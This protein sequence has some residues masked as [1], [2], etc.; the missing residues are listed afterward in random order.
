MDVLIT[1]LYI[2]GGLLLGWLISSKFSNRSANITHAHT[3]LEGMRAVGELSVFK[4]VTKEIVTETDYS[5][6]E[7]G[8]KYLRWAFSQKKLAMIFEFQIDFRYDLRSSQF[9][10]TT[11]DSAAGRVAQLNLPPVRAEIS[12]RS[13]RFYDEQRSKFMPWLLP[14]LL[15]GAFGPGFSEEDKNRLLE[16][17]ASHAHSHAHALIEQLR[18][19]VEASARATL[20]P[21]AQA[22]GVTNAHIAFSGNIVEIDKLKDIKRLS[23][24]S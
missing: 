20:I 6:G 19:E 10:I 11:T 8:R 7:F 24:G 22:L 1:S 4:V 16:G 17:A 21:L 9:S 5:F 15:N 18:P 12:V 2:V 14:D 23:D 3:S 13:L